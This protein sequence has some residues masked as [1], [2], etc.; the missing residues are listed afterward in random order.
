MLAGRLRTR[1]AAARASLKGLAVSVCR[2]PGP[3]LKAAAGG[4]AA[5]GELRASC[6]GGN[7]RA[8][9]VGCHGVEQAD[10]NGVEELACVAAATL[11]P[12]HEQSSSSSSSFVPLAGAAPAATPTEGVLRPRSEAATAPRTWQLQPRSSAAWPAAAAAAAL[13][14]VSSQH[15]REYAA[16]FA[17]APTVPWG[18]AERL[19][20]AL[21]HRALRQ[22]RGPLELTLPARLPGP[23]QSGQPHPDQQ[24]PVAAVLAGPPGLRLPSWRDLVAQAPG[25]P[26]A[27]MAGGGSGAL[28]AGGSWRRP[29]MCMD[30][31][32]A[33]DL[34]LDPDPDLGPGEAGMGGAAGGGVPMMPVVL[35]PPNQQHQ[36]QPE[37]FGGAGGLSS[38]E[39]AEDR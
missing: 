24:H 13:L 38:A 22:G 7:D 35:L 16:A 20:G 14:R 26:T 2:M 36:Q 6:D 18:P 3:T 27:A 37:A 15:R 33:L 17:G 23:G 4:D 29:P 32:V 31:I 19:N 9:A 30:D 12:I 28:A 8:W 25:G 10:A 5:E 21:T 34:D 1:H 11:Q 39:P